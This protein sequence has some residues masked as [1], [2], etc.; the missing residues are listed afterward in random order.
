[1]TN[2]ISELNINEL[3]AVVGGGW[4]TTLYNAIQSTIT[5]VTAALQPVPYSG[6]SQAQRIGY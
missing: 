2:E 6:P 3:D 5:E 4:A 1:M